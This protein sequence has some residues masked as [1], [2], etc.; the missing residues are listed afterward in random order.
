LFW[1]T[2]SFFLLNLKYLP[3]NICSF[4]YAYYMYEFICLFI[5]FYVLCVS[6][7]TIPSA[8]EKNHHSESL[9]FLL[10][11]SI[12]R[13]FFFLVL[14]DSSSVYNNKNIKINCFRGWFVWLLLESLAI[15]QTHDWHICWWNYTKQEQQQQRVLFIVFFSFFFIYIFTV[16]FLFFCSFSHIKQWIELYV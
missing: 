11:F 15:N 4:L 2:S 12:L 14:N 3:V 7:W 13:L 1:K 8:A 10:R 6:V 5:C 9:R 16:F